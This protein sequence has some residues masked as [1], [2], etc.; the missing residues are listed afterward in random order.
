MANPLVTPNMGL[1]EPGIGNTLSPTWATLLNADLGLIDA[2]DHTPG[3]GVQ[4][5]SASILINQDFPLNGFNLTSVNSLVYSAP[6][7]GTPSMLSTFSNGTDLFYK[8]SAGNVIQLTKAGAPNAGTGNIQGLPSTP[9]GGAGISWVNAQST[10]QFLADDG[11]SAANIDVASMVIRYPGS[12]PTPS[13][14]FILLQA[15]TSLASGYSITLPALPASQKIMTL[16]NAGNMVAAYSVDGTTIGITSNQLGVVASGV[17]TTQLADGSVTRPK[18][19]AVG[20]QVSGNT[21]LKQA[22]GT[23]STL[24]AQV[25]ITTTGRPVVLILNPT[26]SASGIRVGNQ[27][28]STIEVSGNVTLLRGASTISISNVGAYLA[29]GTRVYVPPSSWSFIDVIGAGTYTYS[30]DISGTSINSVT[31]VNNCTLLAYEL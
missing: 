7:S 16:D 10:F 20:Q 11:V 8:D 31:E 12:Y 2:H 24:V 4:L 23:A 19:A 5:T 22:L 30:V 28:G 9:I 27:G 17:N 13:G 29:P 1:T 15:P 6:V 14:N 18:Q 3:K 25:T 21:G 26:G